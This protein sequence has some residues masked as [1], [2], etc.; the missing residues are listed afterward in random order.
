VLTASDRV[1]VVGAGQAGVQ[2]AD[3]LR[4]GGFAGVITLLAREAA[5]P[6]QRPPL[7][8][9]FLSGAPAGPLPLRGA[10]FFADH[11]IDA[12]WGVSAERIDTA[13]R[14][15][16]ADGGERVPYTALVLATGADS[17]RLGV[18][19]E[20]LADVVSL[21]TLDDARAAAAALD[22]AR[23]AV[24]VGAGFV[25]LEV[26]AAARARG[27]EVTV[28]APTRR[29]LRRS[30]TPAVSAFLAEAHTLDGV[31]LELGDGVAELRAGAPGSARAGRVAAVVTTSG[32]ELPVDLVVVGV[33]AA[34]ATGLAAAAGLRIEDGVAVDGSLR[35][36][37]ADV[38]AIGDCASFPSAHA[39]RRVR[40]ESVQNAADQA[41]HLATVLLGGSPGPYRELPW[42][43]SHQGRTKVQIAGL[44]RPHAACVVRGDRAAGRFSVFSYDG[45]ELVSVE[46]VNS[47][48]DHLAARRILGAGRT[49]PPEDAEDPGFDLKA[50][51]RMPCPE[52]A[53]A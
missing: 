8:K 4:A 32:R 44:V 29:P 28:L 49:V 22:G 46:S 6:Y 40:L 11:G 21:R 9:D 16:L 33:G 38:Y 27:V 43:W 45:G 5:Q 15:V 35:T 1:V 26:A 17:R 20:D 12:R 53:P 48:A 24:V 7:S 34:P 30:V 36:S 37:A 47:P 13:R 19:G 14:E 2:L 52:P 51:S 50:Y 3:S 42:F 39:G 23:R 18:P 31:R 41:R 10:S 25:G